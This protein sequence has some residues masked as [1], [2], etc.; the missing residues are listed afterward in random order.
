MG[1]K[2]REE[3]ELPPKIR[4]AILL[5]SQGLSWVKCSEEVGVS[6][7]NLRAWRKHP[8][9]EAFLSEAI[10]ENLA[11]AHSLFSDAAPA[12]A[13]RLIHLGLNEQVKPYAQIQAISESFKILQQGV[14]EKENREHLRKIR[15]AL[16]CLENGTNQVIDV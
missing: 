10:K 5:R 6:P 12:L 7:N 3:M 9:F 8:D 11:E 4:Q 13:K 2:K 15:E 14:I 1:K 16:E